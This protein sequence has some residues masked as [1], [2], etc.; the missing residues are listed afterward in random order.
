MCS[1]ADSNWIAAANPAAVLALLDALDA[2]DRAEAERDASRRG[3]QDLHSMIPGRGDI[4][5]KVDRLK[6]DL[7]ARDATIAELHELL[8]ECREEIDWR[9]CDALLTRIDAALNEKEPTP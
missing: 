5:T 8:A 1:E 9:A 3:Y 7:A 6:A 2:L 4:W